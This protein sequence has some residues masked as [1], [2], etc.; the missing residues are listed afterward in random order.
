MSDPM[1]DGANTNRSHERSEDGRGMRRGAWY[2]MPV[3]GLIVLG[4]GV[5]F[6]ARNFGLDLPDH[7]WALFIVVPAAFML[8]T[9]ARFYRI[10]SRLSPRVSSLAMTGTLMLAVGIA[11]FVGVNWAMFWPVLVIIVGLWIIASNYRRR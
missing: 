4:V 8:V 5:V 6:L 2:G 11:L 10:D 7:W 1:N 3:G 9:A